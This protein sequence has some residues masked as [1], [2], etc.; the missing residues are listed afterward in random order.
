MITLDHAFAL[1]TEHKVPIAALTTVILAILINR[2]FFS[3][4]S[5]DT[6]AKKGVPTSRVFQWDPFYGL[7]M[8]YSQ[9]RA[10]KNDYYLEWLRRLHRNRP[11]TFSINFFGIKQICT[12][13]GE[14]L[15]AIQATNFK[16]F[17]LEPMRRKTKG[18]MPFADKGIS[19]ADGKNW[20][21]ARYLV[22]PFFY[23]EVYASIDRVRPYVDKFMTLL[24]QEDGVT[25]DAQPLV[26]RWVSTPP[27]IHT[28]YTDSL[29]PRS[30]QRVHL[31]RVNGLNGL[32]RAC[33]H[34]LDNANS[35]S[36]RPSSCSIL[37]IPLGFQLELVARSC[38]QSA[39]LCQRA[40]SKHLCR[41]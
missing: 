37:P 19:T 18:G 3:N 11:K 27:P 39:R 7:D 14:N 31:R 9:I 32:S 4:P 30:H 34:N 16:D 2:L 23:R 26:Q 10:L 36:R 40:H 6:I 17:G 29:V 15:K 28:C 35:P 13:E 12:I 5:A 25:F 20:E 33:R 24:P 22:K 21:F 41:D 1:A 8:V 38:V